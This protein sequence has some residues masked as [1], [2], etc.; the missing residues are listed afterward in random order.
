MMFALIF[1]KQFTDIKSLKEHQK[2]HREL[3][4]FPCAFC[5]KTLSCAGSLRRHVQ[6]IHGVGE[7]VRNV[8]KMYVV[9]RVVM[10]HDYIT[11]NRLHD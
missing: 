1:Q 4:V 7:K 2:E 6:M 11:R 5:N 8:Y 10:F 9:G 3:D